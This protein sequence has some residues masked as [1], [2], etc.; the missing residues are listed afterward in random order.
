MHEYDFPAPRKYDVR[1]TRQIAPMQAVAVSEPVQHASNGNLGASVLGPHC[2][3]YSTALLWSS[4]IS[5]G[6]NQFT[7]ALL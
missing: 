4:C 5:H 7:L 2:L 6:P 3:H 1:F